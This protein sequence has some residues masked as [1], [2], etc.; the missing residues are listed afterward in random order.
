MGSTMLAN[1][2]YQPGVLWIRHFTPAAVLAG[3]ALTSL[4]PSAEARI[5]RFSPANDVT[6]SFELPRHA[7]SRTLVRFAR[8][9]LSLTS[10]A[11]GALTLRPP[12]GRRG[13]RLAAPRGGTARVR[14]ELSADRGRARLSVGR[15][16]RPAWP[17]GSS[18]RTRS[19]WGAL[20]SAPCESRPRPRRGAR[21]RA[22]RR[23]RRL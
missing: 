7:P 18:P 17:A 9:R 2:R 23:R 22:P 1:C 4:V 19:R 10:G 3:L 14:I 5:H 13:A 20:P 11:G 21:L 6:V 12:A 16:T 8:N 15:K